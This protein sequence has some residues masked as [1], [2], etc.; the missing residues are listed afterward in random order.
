LKPKPFTI[1]NPVTLEEEEKSR[2]AIELE[3]ED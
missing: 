2:D 3:K 1:I